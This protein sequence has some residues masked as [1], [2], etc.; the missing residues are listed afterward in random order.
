M[1]ELAVVISNENEN[2]TPLETI[3]A[4]KK[5]GFN[6]VFAQWYDEEWNDSQFEQVNYAKQV[7]HNIVFAH[8]GYQNINDIWLSGEAGNKLVERYKNDIKECKER[9]INLVVMHLSRKYVA[10]EPNSLGLSR[11]KEITEYAKEL[12]VKV[13]FE[14]T[15]LTSHLDYVMKNIDSDNVGMCFD[16]GHFHAF[17]ND[18]LNFEL[19]KNKIFAVH[20]HDNDSSSD[21]HLLPFD[22]TIDWKRIMEILNKCNYNGPITLEIKYKKEYSNMDIVDFYKKGYEIGKKIINISEEME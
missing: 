7:G 6:S 20:L 22:G 19:Y 21:Q 17:S 13:A 12:N 11:I 2:V 18:E 3:Y 9:G 8:L 1:R 5:A 10:P 15:R 4:I 16:T 14:N